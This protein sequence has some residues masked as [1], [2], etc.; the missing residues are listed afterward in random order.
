VPLSSTR[1]LNS[2]AASGDLNLYGAVA[3]TLDFA[4]LLQSGHMLQCAGGVLLN[5]RCS[6]HADGCARNDLPQ[7]WQLHD[8]QISQI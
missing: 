3:G 5:S 1:L 7:A 2:A 6:L 8:L 4:E